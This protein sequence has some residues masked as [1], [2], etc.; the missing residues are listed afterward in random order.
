M[1]VDF[2]DIKNALKVIA[3]EFDHSLIIQKG[4]MKA[5]LIEM[6]EGEGFKNIIVDFRP[7]AENFAFYF[8]NRIKSEGFTMHDV[9][10]FE[11]PTNSATYMEG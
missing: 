2:G 7:T 8:Y 9:T 4:T 11:T 5:E 10:V 3:D 1:V 6:L